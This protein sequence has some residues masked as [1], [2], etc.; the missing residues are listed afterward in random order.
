MVGLFPVL[1]IVGAM[2][3][4]TIVGGGLA[5]LSLALGLRQGGAPVRVCEAGDYPRHRVCGESISGLDSET[6]ATL[7]LAPVLEAAVWLRHLEWHDAGRRL[8]ADVLPEPARGLSRWA[9]DQALAHAVTAAGGHIETNCRA[10]RDPSGPEAA[11]RVD[12]AGRQ[13]ATHSP[14]IGLKC[15]LADLPNEADL[16]MHMSPHGYVGLSRIEG[17]R[18]NLCGLFRRD[19]LKPTGGRPFI[20]DYLAHCGFN[21]LLKR[22]E[23]AEPVPD[24]DCSV[25]ALSYEPRRPLAGHLALGDAR[26]L[27]PP[28]TGNGMTLAFQNAAMVLPMLLAYSRGEFDWTDCTQ[29]CAEAARVRFGRRLAVAR[30]VQHCLVT[31][32]LFP[33]VATLARTGLFPFHLLFRLTR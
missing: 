21:R 10:A 2:R 13:P 5:G 31:P 9:L 17:G 11:G 15:H 4:I 27:I 22:L 18:Y 6:V 28:F 30:S 26:G 25:A 32:G 1:R 7:G 19:G 8:R 29:R 16:E 23:A 3:P 12:C 33:F 24:S 14:W 20:F